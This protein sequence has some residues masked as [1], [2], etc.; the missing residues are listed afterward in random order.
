[1]LP[2]D[3][4][5]F[6][7]ESCICEQDR[8]L[9]ITPESVALKSSASSLPLSGWARFLQACWHWSQTACT[10]RWEAAQRGPPLRP[11]QDSAVLF[12][13]RRSLC[14]GWN[15][16]RRVGKK[17][18]LLEWCGTPIRRA[19][20]RQGTCKGGG[21]GFLVW[22]GMKSLLLRC[23]MKAVVFSHSN[24]LF[25]VYK[26][27]SVLEALAPN[28]EKTK[29]SNG[30]AKWFAVRSDLSPKADEKLVPSYFHRK[31]SA[32]P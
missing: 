29:N 30:L 11:D 3:F 17:E 2:N 21:T 14:P 10:D 13:R 1:M 25:L 19:E 6:R 24:L 20:C 15:G 8:S 31:E 32:R 7:L 16:W 23:L 4:W 5:F 26:R 9:N 28:V 22:T 12:S 18:G 27:I